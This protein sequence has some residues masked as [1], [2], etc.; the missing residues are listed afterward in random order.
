[1]L[2]NTFSWA[3]NTLIGFIVFQSVSKNF[4]PIFESHKPRVIFA[5]FDMDS[6]LL[7]PPHLRR[8]LACDQPVSWDPVEWSHHLKIGVS[9]RCLLS[10]VISF[11]LSTL[12]I[13]HCFLILPFI[14]SYMWDL[15]FWAHIW[16]VSSFVLKTGCYTFIPKLFKTAILVSNYIFRPNL[17][18]EL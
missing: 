5:E 14:C 7:F 16:C 6:L 9:F 17:I 15:T 4:P 1:M 10:K 12:Y 11:I 2:Q 18:I 3:P 8:S 13:K